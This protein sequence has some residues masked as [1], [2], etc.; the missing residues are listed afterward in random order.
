MEVLSE[1]GTVSV[2]SDEK[3][4]N[5]H[6][7]CLYG[8]N[9]IPPFMSLEHAVL[10]EEGWKSLDPETTNSINSFYHA[11]KLQV[12]DVSIY[13]QGQGN[14]KENNEAV[15]GYSKQGNFYRI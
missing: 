1:N 7:T 14:C 15:C 3:V 8:I 2:T 11:A 6:I 13:A 5:R 10:T 4:I 12:G 9:D